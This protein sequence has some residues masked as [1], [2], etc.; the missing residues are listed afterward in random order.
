MTEAE[1]LSPSSLVLPLWVLL[2]IGEEE[3]ALI[4]QQG[5]SVTKEKEKSYCNTLNN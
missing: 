4:R 5:K 2:L 1:L 3:K